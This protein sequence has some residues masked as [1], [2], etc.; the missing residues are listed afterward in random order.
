MNLGSREYQQIFLL[1]NGLP[2]IAEIGKAGKLIPAKSERV[3][4]RKR[5]KRDRVLC[6]EPSRMLKGNSFAGK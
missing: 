2:Q 6:S 1:Y 3:K 4:I 5:F